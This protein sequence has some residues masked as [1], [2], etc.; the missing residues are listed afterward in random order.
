MIPNTMGNVRCEE[1]VHSRPEAFQNAAA[2]NRLL[3]KV[4]AMGE[5]FVTMPE[6]IYGVWLDSLPQ[7][8]FI[9]LMALR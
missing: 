6:D 1:G 7:E 9:E 2:L 8:E 3:E 4:R 5:T